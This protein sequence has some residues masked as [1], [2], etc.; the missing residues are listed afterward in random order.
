MATYAQGLTAD[1]QSERST[2]ALC[3]SDGRPGYSPTVQCGGM[4]RETRITGSID[5]NAPRER[6]WQALFDTE[7]VRAAMLPAGSDVTEHDPLMPPD[8]VGATTTVKARGEVFTV[9]V[10]ETDPP[11]RYVARVE[12][13]RFGG[14]TETRLDDHEGGTLVQLDQVMRWH[15]GLASLL[16]RLLSAVVTPSATRR[17]L[18]RLKA[19]IESRNS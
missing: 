14:W 11:N 1:D 16:M 19:L 17:S 9:T 7:M 8:A 5:I 15:P 13:S 3:R 2:A 6:V 12:A 10:T 4:A 18:K